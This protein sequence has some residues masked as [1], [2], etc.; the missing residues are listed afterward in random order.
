MEREEVFQHDGT[1][2]QFSN[3]VQITLKEQSPVCW[4]G[5]MTLFYGLVNVKLSL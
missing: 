3:F 4:L 2:S 1:V 5:D